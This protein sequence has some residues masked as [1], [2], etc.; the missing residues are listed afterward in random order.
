MIIHGNLEERGHR[1]EIQRLEQGTVIIIRVTTSDDDDAEIEFFLVREK[2]GELPSF[3]FIVT[4]T[5]FP[6]RPFVRHSH[7]ES[8]PLFRKILLHLGNPVVTRAEEFLPL[9]RWALFRYVLLFM[10]S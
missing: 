1:R 5:Q 10:D 3:A 6:S 2:V 7:R 4:V 8:L 9:L